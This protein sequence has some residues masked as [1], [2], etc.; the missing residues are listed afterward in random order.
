MGQ[1]DLDNRLVQARTFNASRQITGLLLYQNGFFIKALEGAAREVNQL[2][3]R[4]SNDDRHTDVTKL[5][6]QKATHASF[7][8]W[9]MGY[10]RV[11][12]NGSELENMP[13]YSSL[14]TE[15]FDPACIDLESE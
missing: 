8:E 13:G 9:S 10:Y 2:Y 15:N 3:E 1:E 11:S 14:L 12:D 4:I 7:A 6:D 5:Y